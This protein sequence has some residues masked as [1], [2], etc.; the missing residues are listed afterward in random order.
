M[1]GLKQF[2][3]VRLRYRVGKSCIV[4]LFHEG[5][6]AT[7]LEMQQYFLLGI[8]LFVLSASRKLCNV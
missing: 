5:H 2:P 4:L 1:T 6:V 7:V 8:L 3:R